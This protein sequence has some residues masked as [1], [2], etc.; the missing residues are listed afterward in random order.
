M[1]SLDEYGDVF[2]AL[3]DPNRRAVLTLIATSEGATATTIAARLPISRQAV[4]K[5]LTLLDRA[6]LVQARRAGREVR[7]TLRPGRLAATAHELE[8]V[9]AGWDRTLAALKRI[10]ESA[11]AADGPD[12][13]RP[14]AAS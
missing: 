3:A 4:V 2:A 1:P 9:A 13:V 10:A 8:A 7:Y 14:E 5:H 6:R 11:E 12:G